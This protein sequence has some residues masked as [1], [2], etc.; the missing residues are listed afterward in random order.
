MSSA[1]LGLQ[2]PLDLA[3]HLSR[4]VVYPESQTV[5]APARAC[6]GTFYSTSIDSHARQT[7]RMPLAIAKGT[8]AAA[9]CPP[10]RPA[11]QHISTFE[12]ALASTD[13][14]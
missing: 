14:A 8:A 11:S 3:A 10:S 4:P 1:S 7:T 13:L 5:P 9:W 12:D 6:F 2:R